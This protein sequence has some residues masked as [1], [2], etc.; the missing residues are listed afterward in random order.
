MSEINWDDLADKAASQTDEEFNAQMANLTSLK[1]TEIDAFIAQSA[2]TNANA[3]KV[4]K[5]IN[6]ATASN[7]QKA[8]A[9]ANVD[10]GVNFLVSL[11][12]KIV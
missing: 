6:D 3:V 5:E 2:I 4:L 12:T 11:V 1:V 8:V 7:N 9:I 10:K